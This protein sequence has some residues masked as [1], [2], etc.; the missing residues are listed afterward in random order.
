VKTC[1][2][3]PTKGKTQMFRRD[4][5]EGEF[6]QVSKCAR[7]HTGK[8]YQTKE[9]APKAKGKKKELRPSKFKK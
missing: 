7:Q 6:Q 5:T 8:G 9:K 4:L 1:M 2:D 3:H